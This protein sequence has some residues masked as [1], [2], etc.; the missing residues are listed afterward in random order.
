MSVME[1]LAWDALHYTVLCCAVVLYAS[2][3]GD[4]LPR[5][6]SSNAVRT[7]ERD[8]SRH[9]VLGLVSCV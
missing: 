7:L 3:A 9:D 1:V 4:C 5:F 8:V 6:A 2:F